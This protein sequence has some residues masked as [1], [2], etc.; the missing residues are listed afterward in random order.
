MIMMEVDVS[1]DLMQTI[2]PLKDCITAVIGLAGTHKGV[3][4]LHYP[5]AVAFSITSGF[6]G[7]E[8]DSVNEDVEDA[9][10][11]VANMLGG[12]VKAFLSEK[13]RDIDLSLPTTVVGKEYEFQSARETDRFI[14]PF[15]TDAGPFWV[16]MQLEK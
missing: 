11:E 13:G 6:L 15:S 4:A 10:G 1:G 16:D 9:V 8:V 5:N 2:S 7:M 12:D 14:I 3:L